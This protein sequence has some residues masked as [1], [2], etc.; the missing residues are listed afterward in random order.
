M[1]ALCITDEDDDSF[2]NEGLE[3]GT[4]SLHIVKCGLSG[5]PET[6]KTHVRALMLG[7]KRPRQRKSTPV[8]TKADQVTPDYQRI[9]ED[10]LDIGKSSHRWQ[11]VGS[12]SMAR[13]VANTLF[14][15][16]YSMNAD[17]ESEE[18]PVLISRHTSG[19]RRSAYNNMVNNIRK[20][21]KDM[22]GKPNRKRKGLNNVRLVYFVD[23][24]GQP[25]FQEILP[26][27][28]KC[29]I[30]ILVHNLSQGLEHCPEF[31]Y[32]F[33]DES[34]TVPEQVK[35]PNIDIIEQSV[36]SICSNMSSSADYQPH[37]AIVGTF[38][39]KCN[40]HSNAY[41]QMLKE[42]SASITNRLKPYIGTS[43]DKKCELITAS[44]EQC[45]FAIDGSLE[46]WDNNSNAIED[47]K[48]CIHNY[49]D[50]SSLEVPIKYFIFLQNITAY[51]DKKNLQYLTLDQCILVASESEIFM[52]RSDVYKALNQFH[53]WNVILYFPEV[54]QKI[55]F[56]K[57]VFL[58]CKTT[59]LIV[60][61]FQCQ[62]K[63][64]N[65]ENVYFQKSGVFT[66]ALLKNIPSLN[67]T[68]K[69]F[70]QKDFL[71]LLKGLF[72]IA[73]LSPGRYFMPCVLPVSES[74][75][76]QLDA[77]KKCMRTHHV[78]GPLCISF[79]HKKSP[80]GL[81]CAMV[82]ALAGNQRWKLR[83]L[84]DGI[85]LHRNLLEFEL[86]NECNDPIGEVVVIDKNSHLEVYT[87][88]DRN[89]CLYVRQTV[90]DAFERARSKMKYSHSDLYF[91]G[92][93][94][95]ITSTC[96]GLHSTKV[97]CTESNEWKERCSV[98]RGKFILLT[99]ERLVW[100]SSIA[101]QSRLTHKFK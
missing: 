45:I 17:T 15:G 33:G 37:V 93:P 82:V 98:N 7:M 81:F 95:T 22:K 73:E 61:S 31:N 59:D 74:S 75:S 92:L 63:T 11:V 91:V 20:L 80:R 100:F 34:F 90:R 97:F 12:Q 50:K 36:R 56:I 101:S 3:S 87:T 35:A 68:D 78:A 19:K 53:D 89:S 26:N 65:E 86:H 51:A 54:L 13:F 23:V 4:V 30:N 6:G 84:P 2:I 94:C 10:V 55:V 96:Q 83:V 21:L 58:F 49:A 52:T 43:S 41:S 66:N 99:P 18:D 69:D 27:F 39:D 67:L 40:P 79:S 62:F 72:I 9:A 64:M 57:P 44:R 25:Q 38:K 1:S 28:I 32:V 47:L 77:I 29:D 42:K 8:G 71:E 46:G 16:E 70:S 5:P 14:S 76:E 60:A 48:Q 88:C 85:I 24:G